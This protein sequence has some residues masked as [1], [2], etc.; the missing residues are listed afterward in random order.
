MKVIVDGQEVRK[1]AGGDDLAGVYREL[2]G[3]LLANGRTVTQVVLDGKEMTQSEQS[4]MMESPSAGGDVLELNTI[5]ADALICGTLE[6]VLQHM[7][8]LRGG[9]AAAVDEFAKGNREKSLEALQPAL[10]VWAVVCE[11]VQKVAVLETLRSDSAVQ[12][13][14]SAAEQEGSRVLTELERAMIEGDWVAFGDLLEYELPGVVD[15]WE[16]LVKSILSSHQS[17]SQE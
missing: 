1:V 16:E 6:Q 5:P 11:A 3:G 12:V 14:P 15:T 7:D 8:V 10:D 2:V 13:D 9:I 17:D 4:E